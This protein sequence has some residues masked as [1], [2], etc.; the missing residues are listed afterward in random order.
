MRPHPPPWV[1]AAVGPKAGR[2][3]LGLILAVG[4]ALRVIFG[5]V[6]FGALNRVGASGWWDR[7]YTAFGEI[8]VSIVEGRGFRLGQFQAARPPLYPLL[9]AG[10]YRVGGRSD[11]LPILVQAAIGT[12]TV[13]M[14]YLIARAGFDRKTGLLSAA[15]VTV[16]PYYVAHDT[17]QQD[18]VLFTFLTAT[19]VYALIVA[20]GRQGRGREVVAGGCA[21]L[22]LLCRESLL[23][24]LPLAAGWLAFRVGSSSRRLVAVTAFLTAAAVVVSPWLA[25]NAIVLGAPVFSSRLGLRV[26]IGQN[27]A[28]LAHYPWESIDLSTRVALASLSE[29]EQ[30]EVAKLG[31][32][33]LDRWFLRRAFTFVAEQPLRSAWYALVKVAAAFGPLKSPL[34]AAWHRNLLYTASY[35]PLAALALYGAG[36]AVARGPVAWLLGLLIVAFLAVVLPTHAHT[37]HRSHLDVYV[38]VLAARTALVRAG[39]GTSDRAGP[40]PVAQS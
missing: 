15:L 36:S 20:R 2:F 8:A 16:Y 34:D 40:P 31:E 39:F 25:R 6:G 27:P 26:W 33:T 12:A 21:G 35:T 28:T 32:R 14:T 23:P 37:S 11:M 7:G 10:V 4:F 24:F 3:C 22:T 30:A 9:L 18:T 5:L 1:T 13:L 38:V 19:T 29:A 17:A